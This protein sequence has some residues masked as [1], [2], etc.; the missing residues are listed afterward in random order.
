MAEQLVAEMKQRATLFRKLVERFGSDV[1]DVVAQHTIDQTK[2]RVEAAD[3]ELRDLETV[4]EILWDQ[5]V[6]GTEFEVLERTPE[7]LRLRVSKCFF[8]DHMRKMEAGDIG[9]VFY[10]SYDFGFCQGLNPAI[11]F[12]RTQALMVGDGCCDH[13]YEL[14]DG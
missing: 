9:S 11:R 10:C 8:A 2:A 7:I 5:M 13:T 6:E 14:R 1:L 12:T 3:L 4:M